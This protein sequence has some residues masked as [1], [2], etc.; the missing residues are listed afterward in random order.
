MCPCSNVLS[1]VF[2][3]PPN[4]PV[5]PPVVAVISPLSCGAA[6]CISF[7]LKIIYY[8]H[9]HW[10]YSDFAL[11]APPTSCDSIPVCAPRAHDVAAC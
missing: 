6:I 9:Y 8:P 7:A 11:H 10:N 3:A 5:V 1:N 2:S 4:T